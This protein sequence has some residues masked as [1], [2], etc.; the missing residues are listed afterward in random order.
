MPYLLSFVGILFIFLMTS[1]G[2]LTV[3]FH[4]KKDKQIHTS[5]FLSFSGGVM[6]AA[7]LFSLLLPAVNQAKEQNTLP[8]IPVLF[9][10]IFG[11]TFILI[12]DLIMEKVSK[13]EYQKGKKLFFAM[14][15]HNIPEG[16]S[17][18][19]AF[20]VALQGNDWT[21]FLTPLLLA[22]GIGIQNFPEGAAASFP[23]LEETKSTKKACLYGII[24]G[25]VEPIA[26]LIGLF[27][28]STLEK[29]MPFIL[30]FGAGAMLYVVIG[31]LVN[32]EK[33]MRKILRD[34]SF[35]FGFLLMM[36]LDILLG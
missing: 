33:G 28:S 20:G 24:S 22:F 14:T 32:E 31:E 25:S 8:L 15:I 16:L 34:L 13:K 23:M 10:L 1:F 29:W 17:V 30:A 6:L 7:A 12:F 21:S 11:A 27:L 4:K 36:S 9:G 18:G 35:L 19:L 26:A 5:Y 3:L 2:A